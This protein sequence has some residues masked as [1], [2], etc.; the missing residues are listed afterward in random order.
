MYIHLSSNY[1]MVIS[2]QI[3]SQAYDHIQ[4]YGHISH[5]DIHICLTCKY[6]HLY[7]MHTYISGIYTYIQLNT[8]LDDIF[9]YICFERPF[10]GN[11]KH[12][13]LC[14]DQAQYLQ[15]YLHTHRI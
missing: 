1:P 8:Y 2:W 6:V 9:A 13:M 3:L 11:G 12:S 14:L 7:S 5:I 10:K 4:S 15:M